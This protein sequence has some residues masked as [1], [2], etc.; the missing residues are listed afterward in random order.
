[1]FTIHQLPEHPTQIMENSDDLISAFRIPTLRAAITWH[2]Q[3]VIVG[4]SFIYKCD[5]CSQM[6]IAQN[7]KLRFCS[8]KCGNKFRV[9]KSQKNKAKR[10]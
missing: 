7:K 8:H 10:R 9:K 5:E 1:M 2:M 3:S 4:D 6:F